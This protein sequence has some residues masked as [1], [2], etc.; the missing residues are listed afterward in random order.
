MTYRVIPAHTD[1]TAKTIELFLNTIADDGFRLVA[2]DPN[3]YYIFE[4]RSNIASSMTW[5]G[6]GQ[7]ENEH[8]PASLLAEDAHAPA[9]QLK[10]D[11]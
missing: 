1:I 5:L 6:T 9:T 7:T 4:E 3:G 8:A 11:C 10:P 2:I